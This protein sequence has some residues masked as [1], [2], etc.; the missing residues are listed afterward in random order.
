MS[1]PNARFISSRNQAM[2]SLAGSIPPS[3]LMKFLKPQIMK[4]GL[5]SI[6]QSEGCEKYFQS[7]GAR[8]SRTPVASC[9]LQKS[10]AGPTGAIRV[11]ACFQNV[12]L[13]QLPFISTGLQPGVESPRASQPF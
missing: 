10:K 9:G 11:R 7:T 4:T 6:L 5:P 8:F 13:F 3:P 12:I 2:A 1:A